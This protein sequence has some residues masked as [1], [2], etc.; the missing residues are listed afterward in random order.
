MVTFDQLYSD[1]NKLKVYFNPSDDLSSDQWY[2]LDSHRF[3]KDAA[4]IPANTIN[5]VVIYN[6][7]FDLTHLYTQQVVSQLINVETT[8]AK[9]DLADYIEKHVHHISVAKAYYKQII[10]MYGNLLK[11][12]I[13]SS[14][15]D[16]NNKILSE[17]RYN[18]AK[19]ESLA[20]DIDT[21]LEEP[22][23]EALAHV[24]F[25]DYLTLRANRTPIEPTF[26]GVSEVICGLRKNIEII[27]KTYSIGNDLKY[28]N[29]VNKL[30]IPVYKQRL[31]DMLTLLEGLP[32]TSR[33]K[34]VD[35]SESLLN[36]DSILMYRGKTCR[37]ILSELQ[38]A[39][40]LSDDNYVALIASL[41]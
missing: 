6:G 33:S 31:D 14:I 7:E 26:A 1:L 25:I 23:Y 11:F 9:D 35:I 12:T 30:M 16:T 20:P 39:K 29:E 27:N 21:I 24:R 4:T 5:V 28:T 40:P 15:V 41:C 3:V 32:E 17:Y 18:L 19:I 34:L 37:D 36:A 10:N 22:P 38:H 2:I 8:S 13:K